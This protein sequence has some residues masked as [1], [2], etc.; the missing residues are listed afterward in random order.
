ML[1][2]C[3]VIILALASIISASAVAGAQTNERA[4][5]IELF[6]VVSP[7]GR[8]LRRMLL[9]RRSPCNQRDRRQRHVTPASK[10]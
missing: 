9:T 6:P 8:C 10:P 2:R 5:P 7:L 3:T 4:D 1:K